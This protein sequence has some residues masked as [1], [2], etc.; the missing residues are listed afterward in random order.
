MS[1][2]KGVKNMCGFTDMIMFFFIYSFIGWIME[3]VFASIKEKKFINRGFLT[4]FFC[5]IYGFGAVLILHITKWVGSI[6]ERPFAALSMNIFFS[7]ILVT[8]LEYIT[9]FV[10]E[11]IFHCKWWDYSTNI[12]NINGYICVEYSLLWGLMAYVL[13]QVVHPIVS[14]LVFS[15]PVFDKGY[16]VVLLLL[17]FLTDTVKS[18]IDTLDLRK[19]ILNHSNISDNRYYE[20]I[21]IYKRLFLAFP[22]LLIL[23]VGIKNHDIRSIIND[24]MDK[25]KVKVKCR[26]L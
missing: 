20:K 25:I 10:L 13:W 12:L 5:P 26:F 4:G 18:I 11:K 14:G 2:R 16:L 23:N 21:I 6:I 8:V 22:R 19:V 1:N 9:G 7:I 15:I 17:Y 24:R 3:S